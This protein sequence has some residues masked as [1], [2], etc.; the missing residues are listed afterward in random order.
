M[1][2]TGYTFLG[3][4]D[5]AKLYNGSLD[6]D[7]FP[8]NHYLFCG[9]DVFKIQDRNKVRIDYPIIE[10]VYAGAI[11]PKNIEQRAAFDMLLDERTQIKLVTGV[12][13]SGKTLGLGVA[14]LKAIEEG[15]FDKI[16]WV[17]NNVQVKDSD[18]LGALPGTELEKMLPYVMPLADHCGGIEGVSSLI[19]RGKL[20][21]IPLGFLRGRSICNSI[22]ISSEAE[23]LTKAHIQL[24]IGRIDSGS[25]LSGGDKQKIAIARLF[26]ESPDLIDKAIFEKS[27]GIETLVDKLKGE[28]LFGYVHLT[29]SERSEAAKLADKLDE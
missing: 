17:R 1:D 16:V 26:N 27:K 6:L 21:V 15:K 10:S 25:N 18:P 13:G 3:D 9:N 28:K 5:T 29:K 2:Y 12:F 20:E 24:L 23:N 19:Q 7:I 11:K 14:A 8:E 22:I 4:E